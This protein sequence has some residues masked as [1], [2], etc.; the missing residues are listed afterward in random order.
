MVYSF[1]PALLIVDNTETELQYVPNVNKAIIPDGK[2][3]K[4]C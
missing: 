1:S 3:L 2:R 4:I